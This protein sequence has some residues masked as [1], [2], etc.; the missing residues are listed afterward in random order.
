M[1]RLIS[2]ISAAA[3]LTWMASPLLAEM[4]TVRG[5]VVDV[6]CQMKDAAR[7][8]MDHAK[9]ATSCAKKGAAM[10]I[11]TSNGVY[12]ITGDYTKNSNE[13]LIDFVAKNV[14]AKGNVTEKNGTWEIDVTSME[15]AK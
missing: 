14:E 10:G 11:L 15:A 8:G 6:Q 4:K 1:K 5:E 2:A 3:L 13:K 7:K 12:T 9:C